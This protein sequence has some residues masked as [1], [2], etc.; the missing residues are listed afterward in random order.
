MPD[1]GVTLWQLSLG[2][3][4]PFTTAT[5]AVDTRMGPHGALFV[6]TKENSSMYSVEPEP[7]Q[8]N[9][10]RTCHAELLI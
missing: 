9:A 8:P 3:N 5:P 7:E 1:T 4:A 2:T 6:V 10:F